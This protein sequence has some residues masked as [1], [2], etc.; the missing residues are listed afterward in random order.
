MYALENKSL[1]VGFTASTL[2]QSLGGRTEEVALV[3]GNVEEHGHLPV[4]LGSRGPYDLCGRR[5]HAPER[6]AELVAAQKESDALGELCADD[7][8][9][10]LAVRSREE[11]TGRAANWPHYHPA[12]WSTVVRERRNVLHVLATEFV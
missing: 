7:G 12:L 4:A 3:A 6:C 8:L 10:R 5:G 9:L 11:D 1:R 2:P